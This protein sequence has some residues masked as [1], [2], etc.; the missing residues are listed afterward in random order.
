MTATMQAPTR[1][2]TTTLDR[3]AREIQTAH[4]AALCDHLEH[5]RRAGD[6]LIK[7]KGMLPGQFLTWVQQHCCIVPRTAQLYMQVARNWGKIANAQRVAHLSL[8]QAVRL[9]TGGDE[10]ALDETEE[11]V[12]RI[13]GGFLKEMKRFQL[14]LKRAQDSVDQLR[15]IAKQVQRW[16]EDLQADQHELLGRL[17]KQSD[18]AA[19]N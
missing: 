4:E 14:A 6:L 3:L 17:S 16:L 9:L 8:R 10:S 11:S 5:A 15:P 2:N 18:A 13:A 19:C 1:T 12:D 7:V